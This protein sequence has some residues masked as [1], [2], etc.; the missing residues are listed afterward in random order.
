MS[1]FEGFIT[2]SYIS[3]AMGKFIG[4][5]PDVR[6]DMEI[7]NTLDL[8][9]ICFGGPF[10]NVMT[11]TCMTNSGNRLVVF[12]Q[13]TVQFNMRS[14]GNPVIQFNP[15]F[16]YGLI[17]KVHPVQFQER[18][19][20]ACAGVGERGTSGAA[21]Y[22]ANKWQELRGKVEDKP[23]AAV[24]RVEPDVN[25]GRD[26]SAEL[27]KVVVLNGERIETIEVEKASGN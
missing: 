23:F 2:I 13:H 22:L 14:D 10:S 8:D 11:E 17:L 18:V 1:K 15:A 25:F 9:F 24:V 7:R 20:I 27:L 21:W 26:Q 6:S 16:D 12:E 19:W 5:S 3:T 4:R